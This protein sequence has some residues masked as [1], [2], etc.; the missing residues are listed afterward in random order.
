MSVTVREAIGLIWADPWQVLFRRWN[1]KS[2][3]LG[4]FIRGLMFFFINR[5]SGRGVSAMVAEFLFFSVVSGFYGAITQA[6]RHARPGWHAK[7]IVLM[8]VVSTM[9][10]SEFVMHHWMVHTPRALAGTL[11]SIG[12]TI[13]ST[14][15]TFFVMSRGAMV[16]GEEGDPFLRDMKRMPM[17]VWSFVVAPFKS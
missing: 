5:K 14:T 6:F 16:I 4:A 12:F 10:T 8:I 1:W 15:F 17:L 13:L 3:I 9:H 2:A 7:L 11:A